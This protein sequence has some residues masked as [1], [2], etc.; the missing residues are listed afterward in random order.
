MEK[1]K[2]IDLSDIHKI[3]W[4]DIINNM[5]LFLVIINKELKINLI[6]LSLSSILGFKNIQK[7]IGKYWLD[8]IQPSER[9]VAKNLYN[10]LLFN[11]K[12]EHNSLELMNNI[13]LST[14]EITVKWINTSLRSNMILSFGILKDK[15]KL[16][17]DYTDIDSF[18]NYHED[19]IQK[20][21][22]LIKSYRNVFNAI[23]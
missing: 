17:Y 22:M 12:R 13:I 5:D 3:I 11:K 4:D 20:D 7:P 23:I 18:R 21:Q 1:I 19:V 16:N 10:E 2:D 15:P 9:L 14:G 6:N 8:F